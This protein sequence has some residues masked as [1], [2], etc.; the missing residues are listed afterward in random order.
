MGRFHYDI[1]GSL[2]QS[3]WITI[4]FITF[5]PSTFGLY[6]YKM[7]KNPL[8]YHD[9]FCIDSQIYGESEACAIFRLLSTQCKTS[10]DI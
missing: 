1:E 9:V 3:F 7:K 2:P 5:V 8:I 4:C 10:V 6:V